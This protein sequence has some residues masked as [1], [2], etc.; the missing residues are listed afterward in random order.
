MTTSPL[1]PSKKEKRNIVDLLR[2]GTRKVRNVSAVWKQASDEPP[3]RDSGISQKSGS[4]DSAKSDYLPE[5][6]RGSEIKDAEFDA[7]KSWETH[8]ERYSIGSDIEWVCNPGAQG[9]RELAEYY[10]KI[11]GRHP[12][13]IELD[14]ERKEELKRK[15][16]TKSLHV[17]SEKLP[18]QR[19]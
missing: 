7:D 14:I 2:N 18:W 10:R 3:K 4:R 15:R 12:F 6:F 17:K 1:S 11:I 8:T 9:A 16:K 19:P 13:E 5:R